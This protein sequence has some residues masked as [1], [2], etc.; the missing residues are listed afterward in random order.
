MRE[1]G[2]NRLVPGPDYMCGGWIKTF[3]LSSQNLWRV[4]ID[5]RGLALSR[6]NT[7][8]L[9]LAN[10]GQSLAS[11]GSVV[12]SRYLNLMFDPTKATHNK[13]FLSTPTVYTQ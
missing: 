11:N 5:V 2:G 6:W 9:L 3:Q 4:S 8:P 13:L 10:S 7:T 12:D 1:K